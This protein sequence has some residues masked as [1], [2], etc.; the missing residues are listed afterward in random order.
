MDE[1]ANQ[2]ASAVQPP[3][4]GAV[5]AT[6]SAV[7]IA[8]RDEDVFLQVED[9]SEY[10]DGSPASAT[11]SSASPAALPKATNPPPAKPNGQHKKAKR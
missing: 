10:D 7:S 5:A 11:A 3:S 2:Q 1:D 9:Q 4:A 8:T 6:D